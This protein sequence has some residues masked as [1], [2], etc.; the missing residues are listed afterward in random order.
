M[1]YMIQG[2]RDYIKDRRH[3]RMYEAI[4]REYDQWMRDG[5]KYYAVIPAGEWKEGS[6][7]HYIKQRKIATK[8]KKEQ[9]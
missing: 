3:D 5:H 1:K 4:T 7:W 6:V 2:I 8:V 9:Q